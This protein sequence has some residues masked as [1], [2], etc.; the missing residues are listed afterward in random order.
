MQANVAS[1]VTKDCQVVLLKARKEYANKPAHLMD[2]VKK[3]TNI[4]DPNIVDIYRVASG[5]Q[6]AS[7]VVVML[8]V[9]DDGSLVTAIKRPRVAFA[10][11]METFTNSYKQVNVVVARM[12]MNC[13]CGYPKNEH[14]PKY[15]NEVLGNNNAERV[16]AD[17][18]EEH[19]GS[20]WQIASLQNVLITPLTR[21]EK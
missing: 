15:L 11:V 1:I 14:E 12:K 10:K 9:Q 2:V 19:I 21:K 5:V 4:T 6:Y 16:I 13:S 3:M 18:Y 8:E 17:I 7:A 20:G